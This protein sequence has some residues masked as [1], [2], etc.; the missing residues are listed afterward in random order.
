MST[1]IVTVS[2]VYAERTE[3]FA[4]QIAA[5]LPADSTQV[6]DLQNYANRELMTVLSDEQID[7]ESLLAEL[8]SES[9]PEIRILYGAVAGGICSQVETDVTSL[10]IE[11][12]P[13]E[14]AMAEAES[15]IALLQ[16]AEE[17]LVDAEILGSDQGFLSFVAEHILPLRDEAQ[18]IVHQSEGVRD[19]SIGIARYLLQ[20]VRG[21]PDRISEKERQQRIDQMLSRFSSSKRAKR[22][23]RLKKLLW[24]IVVGSTLFFKRL[25]DIIGSAT[26]LLLLS[27]LFLVVGLI[28]KLTDGGNVFYFQ[29]RVGKQ[30]REF[31]FPKFRSMVANADKLKDQLL[32]QSERQGDVTFKMKKDPRVTPIGRFIRR[33]SIDEL[34]QLWCVLKGDMSLVG[35]RPPLPR[36]VAL[37]T[38]EDRRRLEVTPGLTGIWQVSGR[39]DIGFEDQVK[40]DVLYIESHN[41]WLDIKVLFKTIP[42]V[43]TGKGAY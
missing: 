10:F 23:Y 34:P 25:I 2:G 16:L 38:Q 17:G 36:E 40:L 8:T 3:A 20:K 22:V 27:P 39:A 43:L 29:R 19:S 24:T 1:M 26:A 31:S 30:G 12:D 35:P 41:I 14:T 37:Y 42:A 4:R 33:F 28:I 7:R 11:C 15:R 13:F 6:Y 5:Y 18:I 9:G 21:N 32:Q